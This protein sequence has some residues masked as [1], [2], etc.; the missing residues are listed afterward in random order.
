MHGSPL[1]GAA[2]TT[3]LIG[4][5]PAWRI[6]D[7]HTCPI[8]NAPPPVCTG[9]P[10]GPGITG[11]GGGGG[12]GVT[13]IGGMPG[14]CLGDIVTEPGAIAPLPPPNQIV[15]GCTTVLVGQ[16]GGARG[17]SIGERL[18]AAH[19]ASDVKCRGKVLR[20]QQ[21]PMSCAQASSSMVIQ[22]VTGS[23]I[24]EE[25]LR[26]ESTMRGSPPGYDPINGTLDPDIVAGLNSH[27]VA[28]NGLQYNPSVADIEQGL[29]GGKPVQLGMNN[30]G[31]WVVVDGVKTNP[32][33]TKS[34]LVRD[35]GYP[36]SKGCREIGPA[37][38]Q[39][40]LTNGAVMISFP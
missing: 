3:V 22:D 9:T 4:G 25:Q 23:R 10:H 28:N 2:C 7:Q 11:P 6:G 39:N 35:P 12:E 14:A 17:A 8:P 19:A 18:A 36:G 26:L 34:L 37:E 24:S 20:Q 21:K 1:L 29:A 40:R 31:H 5:Q 38:L 27:G 32:D 16:G 30:P 15:Q 33:G 13:L